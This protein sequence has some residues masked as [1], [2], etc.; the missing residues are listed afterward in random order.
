MKAYQDMQKQRQRLPA[1]QMRAKILSTIMGNQVVVVSGETGTHTQ[2]SST[3]SHP[4]LTT[5]CLLA[6]AGCGKT[7]QLPQIVLDHL[8]Q[9]GQGARVNMLCTQPRRISAIGVAE[10]VASE[11]AERVGQTVGTVDTCTRAPHADAHR[12]L[13]V[14]DRLPN[15][16]GVSTIQGHSPPLLHNR[17]AA[18]AAPV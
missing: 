17:C 15:P 14:C 4:G 5:P 7:T 10:R 13:C 8:V 12:V 1:F 6:R 3:T 9:S 18:A 11:R 2:S 16:T